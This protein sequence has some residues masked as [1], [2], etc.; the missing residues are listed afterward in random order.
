MTVD[1]QVFVQLLGELETYY[2]REFTPFV[3]R[4]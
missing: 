3:K 2:K 1:T 4:I